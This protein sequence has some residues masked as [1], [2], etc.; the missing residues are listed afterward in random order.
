MRSKTLAGFYALVLLLCCTASLSSETLKGFYSGSGG[1]SQEVHRVIMIEFGED[2]SALVQQNWVGKDPQVWHGRWTMDG[3]T[4]T[5]AFNAE[6]SESPQ[7]PLVMEMK[8]SVM[9]PTSWD[10]ATLGVLGPPKLAPF[11]G[12]NIKQHS[13]A[14]C[15]AIRSSDASGH[16]TTWDSRSK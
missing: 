7:K 9:T 15:Q 11:G 8:R 5:V 1:L 3:K 13:V 16:C 14:T 2:G 6:K 12:K 4:V 10:A